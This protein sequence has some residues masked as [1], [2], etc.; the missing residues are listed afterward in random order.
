MRTAGFWPPLMLTSPTPFS[1]EIFGARRVS[2]RSSTCERGMVFGGDSQGKHGR[3][4]GVGL[5][6]DRR[7]GQVRGQEALR[8][9][10]GRLHLFLADVDAAATG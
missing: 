1:C 5:A 6:I 8:G 10:D 4:G 3:V 7:R 9:V 2:T